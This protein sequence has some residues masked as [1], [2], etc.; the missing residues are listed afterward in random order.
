MTPSDDDPDHPNNGQPYDGDLDEG[1]CVDAKNVKKCK[2][3]KK[4][5]CKKKPWARRFC[6]K[7]C[8]LCG[9]TLYLNTWKLTKF[10]S[11][12]LELML[13]SFICFLL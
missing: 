6:R 13:S 1:V 9:K 10:K 12:P 2:L 4:K 3:V 11:I 5:G 7:T 8:E